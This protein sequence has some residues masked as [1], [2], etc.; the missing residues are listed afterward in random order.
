MLNLPYYKKS[1]VDEMK[2]LLIKLAVILSACK[3]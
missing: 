2:I 1:E 3:S